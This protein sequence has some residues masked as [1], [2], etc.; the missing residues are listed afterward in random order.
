ML[1]FDIIIL[2]LP[3]NEIGVFW[4]HAYGWGAARTRESVA[5]IVIIWSSVQNHHHHLVFGPEELLE[6]PRTRIL[7]AQAQH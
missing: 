3:A 4:K 1:P 6:W 7:V 2:E 5:I